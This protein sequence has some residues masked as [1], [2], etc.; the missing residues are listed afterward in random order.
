MLVKE[1]PTH[2]GVSLRTVQRRISQY[3]E[4]HGTDFRLG[5]QQP[6]PNELIEH[7]IKAPKKATSPTAVATA[8]RFPKKKRT[9]SEKARVQH[10]GLKR[11]LYSDVLPASVLLVI[12]IADFFA[13]AI[14]ADRIFSDSF[15]LA[16]VFFGLIGLFTGIGAVVTFFRM[17]DQVAAFRYKVAFGVAQFL[18][19]ELAVHGFNQWA[20]LVMALMFA[21]VFISVQSAIR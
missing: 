20:S 9:G 7:F 17:E 16:W 3:N 14:V 18:V 15:S 13:F 12:L 19:F 1:L 5:E 2:M 21:G 10:S 8:S 6:V 11:V 4:R